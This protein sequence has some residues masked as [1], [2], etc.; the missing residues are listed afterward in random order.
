MNEGQFFMEKI[1]IL[2]YIRAVITIISFV[3]LLMYSPLESFPPLYILLF[4]V[5]SILNLCIY[6]LIK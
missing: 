2:F 3:P 1:I 4:K 5:F 6:G